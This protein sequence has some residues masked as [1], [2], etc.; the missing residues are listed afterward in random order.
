MRSG[1]PPGSSIA[2]LGQVLDAMGA[3]RRDARPDYLS[4]AVRA[5]SEPARRF[6]LGLAST[7][8]PVAGPPSCSATSAGT[9]T[10]A[11]PVATIWCA[12]S[13]RF[14][15]SHP[16]PSPI[17]PSFGLTPRR[18][19]RSPPP[20]SPPRSTPAPTR[21]EALRF[22]V[23]GTVLFEPVLLALRKLAHVDR[24]R[25]VSRHPNELGDTG[26]DMP[27]PSRT[28]RTHRDEVKRPR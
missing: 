11:R 12:P 15:G 10:A 21:D 27:P 22:S 9:P 16:A 5:L 7:T 28:G 4:L 23:L 2:T 3:H 24:V 1:R 6:R 20:R 19:A 18:R 8:R 25:E 17:P 14:T 26:A 13:S